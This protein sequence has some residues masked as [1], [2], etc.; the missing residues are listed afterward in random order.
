MTNQELIRNFVNGATRGIAS[1]L[2]IRGNEL[3]NYST[4][5][6]KRIT[7]ENG[8]V[9]FLMNIKRYSVSTSKIQNYLR[10]ELTGENVEYFEGENCYYWNMGYTGADTIKVSDV[11]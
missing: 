2:Y 7:D 10:A 5:L 11:Y 6:A 8:N 3:V 1:H 9:K 4:V